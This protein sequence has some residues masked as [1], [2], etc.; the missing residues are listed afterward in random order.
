MGI[1][2]RS[3]AREVENAGGVFVHACKGA[4][5]EDIADMHGHLTPT[6]LG[7]SLFNLGHILFTEYEL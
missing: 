1:V 5:I 4:T 7:T 6:F 3:A 2:E